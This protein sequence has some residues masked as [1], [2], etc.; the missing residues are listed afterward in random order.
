MKRLI[1]I[2][3]S[4]LLCIG[5]GTIKPVPVETIYN[6]KDSTAIHYVDSTVIVPVERIKDVVPQY[7]TLTME[8][9]MAKSVSYVDTLTHTLKGTL[10][11]KKGV[12]Y[13]YIFK[14]RIEYKDSIIT[15]E[16]PVPVEVEKTVYK[17]YWYETMLWLLASVGVI[18]IVLQQV[19]RKILK[20]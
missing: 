4:L 9:S 15:K 17:H 11:N 3:I 18:I 14:D 13:K 5:C 7:D 12:E 2:I 1:T 16:V 8:T 19:K 20:R 10:E 6:I